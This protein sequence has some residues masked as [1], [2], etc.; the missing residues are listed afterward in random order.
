[1]VVVTTIKELFGMHYK[2]EMENYVAKWSP[3]RSVDG[4]FFVVA[5]LLE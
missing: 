3:Y 2:Q 4:H 5:L 1:M